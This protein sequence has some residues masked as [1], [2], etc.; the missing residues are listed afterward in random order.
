MTRHWQD[1]SSTAALSSLY[2][3]AACKRKITG[4]TLP[5]SGL[6]CYLE[7]RPQQLEAYRK[8]CHF[9]D[10]GRLPPTF[11]HVMAFA[12]QLQV[13]TAKAFPFPLL[14]MVHL[15]NSIRVV[16]PLGCQP[17]ALLGACGEPAAT[18]EGC[19]LRHDYRS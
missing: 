10:D 12:L 9:S 15:H 11:P 3:R 4:D 13:L 7:V 16:R 2:L 18:R 14:G 1:L 17:P 19:H 8:L 6:R 5:D